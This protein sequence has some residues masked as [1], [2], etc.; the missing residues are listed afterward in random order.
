MNILEALSS[1]PRTS[2]EIQALL[3]LSQAS[4]SRAVRDD[5]RV[6][7]LPG[8]KPYSYAATRSAFGLDDKLPISNID[9]HGNAVPGA[10]LR[11]LTPRAYVVN[12]LSGS[13]RLLAGVD[14]HGVF[15]GLPYYMDDARPQGFLGRLVA[16]KLSEQSDE[17]SP[18][19]DDW[20]EEQVGRYLAS[21]G[22]DLP[23]DFVFGISM[24]NRL[25]TKPFVQ[26][27]ADYASI[28]DFTLEGFAGGSS[29]GG[30][31]QKFTAFIS[32]T[33][34]HVIVKFTPSYDDITSRRWRD[35]LITEYHALTVLSEFGFTAAQTQLS[36]HSGRYFLE[37]KR[38][39]RLG[40]SGRSSMISLRTI[41]AEY[42][43]SGGSWVEVF[44][45]LYEQELVSRFDLNQVSELSVFGRL[46][47]NTDMHL[48]N[49]SVAMDGDRFSLLPVYDMCSM[50]FAPKGSEVTQFDFKLPEFQEP[51]SNN[52]VLAAT[53]FWS[54]VEGDERT[55]EGLKA[56]VS[57]SALVQNISNI[58]L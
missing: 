47:N 58:A 19:P 25:R 6:I 3:G 36:E 27:R 52:V 45:D 11:P 31:Q 18:E 29:A 22:D 9:T 44:T 48:G 37:S 21:N 23:G 7:R 1:G 46:I 2:K 42:V 15:D 38:F 20:T 33:E 34:S 56:F 14:G 50:G 55:S 4:V 10:V 8:M 28:A 43:G 12:L 30:E 49:L 35:I 53:E 5:P 16:Q 17:F 13:S 39:D 40:W 54:R 24:L 57:Q 51:V 32:A 26:S 41:D